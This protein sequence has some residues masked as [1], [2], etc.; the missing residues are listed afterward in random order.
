MPRT[1][2]VNHIGNGGVHPL[3]PVSFTG[4]T[5]QTNGHVNGYA[6]SEAEGSVTSAASSS[7][8]RGPRT[9]TRQMGV[10]DASHTVSTRTPTVLTLLK[11]YLRP[12]LTTS[13]FVFAALFVLVPLLSFFLRLRRRRAKLPS[14]GNATPARITSSTSVS[15]ASNPALGRMSA[16]DV[17]RRLRASEGGGNVL[18]AA[19]REVYRAVAD[20]V[21][22]AGSGLV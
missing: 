16:E 20:A 15:G 11:A 7:T 17:R 12:Y 1:S 4:E 18:S 8:T 2:R 21:R 19:W 10:G 6:P 13:N 3:T 5:K 14:T 22:M 9:R